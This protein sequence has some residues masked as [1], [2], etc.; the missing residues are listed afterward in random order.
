MKLVLLGA[1]GAGKGTQAAILSEKLVIPTISTGNILR[2]AVKAG[3]PIGRKAESY[4]KAG[5]LV[6]DDVIMDIIRERVTE[7]DCC[8]GYIFD[9][10]PRTIAQA[11]SLEAHGIEV[12][13]ALSLEIEDEVIIERMSG[14]RACHSCGATYHIVNMPPKKEGICDVCGGELEIRADDDPQVVKSR[15][16]TYHSETE[17]LKGFYAS[18]GKLV[19][20]ENQPTI[21]LTTEAIFRALGL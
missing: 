20:V 10:M 11:E 16:I 1:P 9:G 19:S 4:M 12:E 8:A 15:L 3:T 17:P 5:R 2:A 6:P 21:A 18:R 14:R 13:K 7:S